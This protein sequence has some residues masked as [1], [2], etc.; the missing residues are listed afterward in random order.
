MGWQTNLQK[1]W[2]DSDR[3]LD[4]VKWFQMRMEMA[5]LL[6]WRASATWRVYYGD[7]LWFLSS[8]F[9][10]AYIM[11]MS[12]V[13]LYA[14]HWRGWFSCKLGLFVLYI[15]IF[16]SDQVALFEAGV[17]LVISS[18]WFPSSVS[19]I[20]STVFAIPLCTTRMF[21][22]I[23]CSWHF[24]V[25]ALARLMF[26]KSCDSQVPASYISK[27]FSNTSTYIHFCSW[28]G[29]MPCETTCSICW[30]LPVTQRNPNSNLVSKSKRKKKVC[31][32]VAYFS[33]STT[34]KARVYVKFIRNYCN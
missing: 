31:C 17:S 23:F 26:L 8:S 21:S 34:F 18:C 2:D 5:A 1:K 9:S 11:T 25:L 6:Q 14:T 20:D 24:L 15:W 16:S 32:L 28:L 33:T 12:P 27:S 10:A 13:C 22:F 30:T 4:L 29:S 3:A 7:Y 19:L